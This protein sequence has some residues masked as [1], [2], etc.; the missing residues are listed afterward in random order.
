MIIER[1]DNYKNGT[2]ITDKESGKYLYYLNSCPF[3]KH[4]GRLH[5]I[6]IK[7]KWAIACYGC[8]A[9]TDFF[10][11]RDKALNAPIIENY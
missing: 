10:E 5:W 1:V 8:D 4:E 7:E 6:K 3:C 9:S 11:D 2:R